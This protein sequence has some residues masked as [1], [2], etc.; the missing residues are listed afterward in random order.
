MRVT[1]FPCGPAVNASETVAIEHLKRQLQNTEGD[2]EWILLTNL[3]FSVTHQFQSDEIDIVAIGPPGV[4]VLDTKHWTAGWVD[5]NTAAVE[6]EADKVTNKARKLGTTARRIAPDLPR[7]DGVFLLTQPASKIKRLIGRLVR[8]VTFCTLNQWKD[9]IGFDGPRVLSSAQITSLSRALAPKSAV[10]VDG[11]LRRLA[12]YVN[13][14][15]QT[16]REQRFHRVYKGSHPA[17]R[18]RVILH[19]YDLSASDDT[20]AEARA[21]RE[22]EALQR[23]QLYAWAPRILDSWQDA[24][25]YAGEMFFF[26][27][28]DPAAPC[29]EDRASDETWSSS[30]RLLFARD[31]IRSLSEL[32]QAGGAEEPLVHRNLTP[33]TVLVRHD[34]S[35][36]FTG[37]DR[38]RIPSDI[39]VASSSPP[40]TDYPQT[41]P[42]EVQTQGLAAADQRSDVYS[43]CMCLSGLFAARSNGTSNR[44]QRRGWPASTASRIR[45]TPLQ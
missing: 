40:V 2:D 37:F 15:L 39:S 33:R 14:E 16:P 12:G 20:N 35:P 3:A 32:H 10:A 1:V 45:A 11:S 6:H 25:G 38:T 36:I 17:R 13:L 4:R 8:G 28:V 24:P 30:S 34:N 21:K 42:P 27:V 7:V 22:A 23:L 44:P 43:L 41:V 18:D 26:T 5:A 31:A 19:L 29:I 9:A